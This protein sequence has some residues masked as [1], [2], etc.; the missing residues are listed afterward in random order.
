MD[1]FLVSCLTKYLSQYFSFS[2][3]PQTG[4][5]SGI[6]S[7]DTC[8]P[9]ASGTL[10]QTMPASSKGGKRKASLPN[11]P[12]TKKPKTEA[13]REWKTADLST[14]QRDRFAWKVKPS[15]ITNLS[16]DPVHVFVL[17]SFFYDEVIEKIVGYIILYARSKGNDAFT[18][19]PDEVRAFLGILVVFSYVVLH[20]VIDHHQHQH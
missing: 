12:N 14:R 16:T 19:T 15:K 18:T 3:S 13:T 17:W 8:E 11:V 7:V 1:Y 5:E 6:A 4:A 2:L 9:S 10:S 20:D